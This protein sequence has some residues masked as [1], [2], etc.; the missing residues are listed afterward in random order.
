MVDMGHK[1]ACASRHGKPCDCG[2]EKI[3]QRTRRNRRRQE[4]QASAVVYLAFDNPKAPEADLQMLACARYRNKTFTARVHSG[5]FP[6]LECA[7]CGQSI[8]RFGWSA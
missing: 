3:T 7:A 2:G 8:G 4:Q 5:D 6:E 1:I